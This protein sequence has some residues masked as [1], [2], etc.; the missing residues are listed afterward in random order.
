MDWGF[1]SDR[2]ADAFRR[3]R[4]LASR[5]RRWVAET[6]YGMIRQA[7]RVDFALEPQAVRSPAGKTRELARLLAYLVLAGELEPAKAAARLPGV[8]FAEVLRVDERIARESHRVRRLGLSK[9][10]PDW[11][12]ARFLTEYGAEAEALADALNQRA[13][14]TVRANGVKITREALRARLAE[15]GLE[16]RPTKLAPHG[17]V[18]ETRV[19][20]FGLAAFKEGLFEVQD[21]ASQLVSELVRPTSKSLVVD[22]CA[23]AGGKTLALAALMASRG[24]VIALDIH[25]RKLEELRRRARRAGLSNVRA[26]EVSPSAYPDEILA[27][28]GKADRVLVDAPCS[29]IGALRRNPEARWRLSE[30]DLA[31]L[32]VEQ[33]AILRQAATLVAPGGR[34]LYATCTVFSAENEEVVAKLCQ[35]EWEVVPITEILGDAASALADSTGR[36][37]KTL[38]HRHDT[39]GFFAAALRRSGK[40][41]T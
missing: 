35:G 17:L 12:A 37:L 40:L 5:E 25:G 10:L 15:E 27:L 28:Q 34:L 30:E 18:L 41:A 13:P 19:N 39:D 7:R 16:A 31:R 2:L 20:V 6:L 1:A 9:S 22:A 24:R 33:E 38:P 8:D 3:E 23:G 36:F 29:G 11:L 32:P 14:L 21:E 26:V 4:K